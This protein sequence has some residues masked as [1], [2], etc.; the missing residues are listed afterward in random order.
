MSV[1]HSVLDSACQMP[2]TMVLRQPALWSVAP[3]PAHGARVARR[4][5]RVQTSSATQLRP[6]A[7]ARRP[8]V[9][10]GNAVAHAA[11][12]LPRRLRSTVTPLWQRART[13]GGPAS[14][15]IPP[16]PAGSLAAPARTCGRWPT[17]ARLQVEL[18]QARLQLSQL[19]QHCTGHKPADYRALELATAV[20]SEGKS[21]PVVI[22]AELS[23]VALGTTDTPYKL[24]PRLPRH[25]LAA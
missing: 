4:T 1:H 22:V 16:G 7:Y 12:A 9:P 19:A 14:A 5:T 2:S 8:H 10:A 21:W 23:G 11:T 6:P 24:P 20:R 13:A 25:G 15:I 3:P 17:P 18:G